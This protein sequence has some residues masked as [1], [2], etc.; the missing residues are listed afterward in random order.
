MRMIALNQGLISKMLVA[1]DWGQ[2][3]TNTREKHRVKSSVL[4]EED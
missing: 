4:D 3:E 1:F 2:N